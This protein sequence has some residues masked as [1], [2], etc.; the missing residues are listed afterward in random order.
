MQGANLTITAGDIVSVSAL[1][2][3]AMP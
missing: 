1:S 2:Y 3:A